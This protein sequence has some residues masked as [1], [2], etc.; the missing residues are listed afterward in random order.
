MSE[1]NLLENPVYERNL[2]DDDLFKQAYQMLKDCQIKIE[3]ARKENR[4]IGSYGDWLIDLCVEI[5]FLS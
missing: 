4:S 2:A 1:E 5:S 3:K